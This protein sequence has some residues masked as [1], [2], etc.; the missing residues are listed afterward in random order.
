MNLFDELTDEQRSG[1]I[2]SACGQYR[3]HL[4]R[5]WDELLPTMVW[6]MLN[7]STADATEDDPTIRRCIGFAKREGCG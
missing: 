5:R 6:V 2:I 7:P 3:Y 4:W 1:A